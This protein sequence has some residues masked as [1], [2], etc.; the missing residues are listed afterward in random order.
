MKL[1]EA[2]LIASFFGPDMIYT[3]TPMLAGKI[4]DFMYRVG[5]I[6]TKAAS[7]KDMYFPEVH[8]LPGT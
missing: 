1:T 6:K 8:N 5:S 3:R 2:D 7:W 4:L